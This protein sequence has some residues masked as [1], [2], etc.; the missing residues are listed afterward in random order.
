MTQGKGYHY[1]KIFFLLQDI[2]MVEAEA[3]I[4]LMRLTLT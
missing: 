2:K 3:E 1:K 4:S